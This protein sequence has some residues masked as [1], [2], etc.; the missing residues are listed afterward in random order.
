MTHRGVPGRLGATAKCR[1]ISRLTPLDRSLTIGSVCEGCGGWFD[2]MPSIHPHLT[3]LSPSPTTVSFTVTTSPPRQSFAAH[4]THWFLLGVR[5][6]I[7][8]VTLVVLAS[9]Y[10]ESETLLSVYVSEKLDLVPWLY[11]GAISAVILF[12]TLRRFHIGGSCFSGPLY[13]TRS[14]PFLNYAYPHCRRVSSHVTNAR[15]PNQQRFPL[16]SP[17]SY[18]SIHSDVA[19]PR[20]LCPRGFP[21]LRGQ[22]LSR[23]CCGRRG[24]GSRG[25]SGEPFRL[26]MVL[27]SRFPSRN[28]AFNLCLLM[29]GMPSFH[30]RQ[31]QHC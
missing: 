23:D 2:S 3:I 4:C 11:V 14:S 29:I 6:L 8:L 22:I 7:A 15:H 18:Y 24:R 19:D 21:G 12:L 20:H 30:C 31:Y 26:F 13:C 27:I 5:A 17:T 10:I 28:A 1:D 16:L 9:R 25:V